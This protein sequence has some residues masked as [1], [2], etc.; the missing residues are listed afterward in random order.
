MPPYPYGPA[1]QYK[2]SN[3]GLYGGS[4]I[5]YGNK[6]S[7]KN[8]L[9]SRR[10]WHP[11]I[12]QKRLWSDALGTFVSV[13]VQA[14]V[15]RTIDKV[16]GLDTYLLGDKPARIKELGIEGWRL[17]WKVSRTPSVRRR[18]GEER[19]RL[20][21]PVEGFVASVV[22][23]GVVQGGVEGEV[24]RVSGGIVEQM[25]WEGTE[26][27]DLGPKGGAEAALEGAAGKGETMEERIA[28]TARNIERSHGNRV[29]YGK[30]A[31]G[32][33]SD[34][35]KVSHRLVGT[36]KEW[37]K[38]STGDK[39]TTKQ[40]KAEKEDPDVVQANDSRSIFSKLRGILKR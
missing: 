24:E 30:P 31:D 14:R 21:L 20:G 9:K 28:R 29:G 16:G 3:S 2:Q 36:R 23:A 10:A 1:L 5:Q 26:E 7:A 39:D 22:P 40:A 25:E 33:D 4:T 35:H 17:R 13:K 27:D 38:K 15:L 34:V 37:D 12:H 32:N 11:N 18:I 19:V 6:V 8:E